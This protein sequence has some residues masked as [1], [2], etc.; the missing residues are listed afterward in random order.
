MHRLMRKRACGTC[1]NS[2]VRATMLVCSESELPWTESSAVAIPLSLGRLIWGPGPGKYIKL[3][4]KNGLSPYNRRIIVSAS[5]Q[6]DLQCRVFQEDFS[7]I[8]IATT[9]TGK[10]ACEKPFR[11]MPW[12]KIHSFGDSQ[13]DWGKLT[14]WLKKHWNIHRMVLEG[15]GMLND[16]FFRRSL[17]DEIFLTICPVLFWRQEQR[18]DQ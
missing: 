11:T 3:R 13:I 15:G 4:K 1:L 16:A 6:V 12:V 2:A 10:A 17:V 5:G 9:E 8:L 7:P 18:H 14:C